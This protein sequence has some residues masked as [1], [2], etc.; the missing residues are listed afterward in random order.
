MQDVGIGV[1]L[2]GL[3]KVAPLK[4]RLLNYL[5]VAVFTAYSSGQVERLC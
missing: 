4:M 5:Q 2:A 1:S 3:E